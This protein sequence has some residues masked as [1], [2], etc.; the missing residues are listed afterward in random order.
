MSLSDEKE[1]LLSQLVDHE[2]PADQADQVLA[3]ILDELAD[4]LDDT[5]SGRR[6]RDMLQLRQTLGVWRQ[7]ELPRAI[8]ALPPAPSA[9]HLSHAPWRTMS[10]AVAAVL[11]GILV[12]AGFY[13]GGQFSGP[14][15]GTPI[16]Q[17]NANSAGQPEQASPESPR[18]VIVVTPE[19]RREIARAFALHE[20]VA[21]PLSWYVADD[22]TIHVAP[23]GKGER[24]QQTIAVVLRMT[25]A[26]LSNSKEAKTYVIVCRSND[27]AS[28]ELPQ[29]AMAKTSRLRLLSTVSHG[30]VNLQYVLAVEGSDRAAGDAAL[31]GQRRLGLGQTGLGQ[32]A[33]N[34]CLVNVDA[35]A[36]V[37]RGE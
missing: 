17:N 31:A 6:L 22:S 7:Q 20:S 23:L 11:G 9:A 12:A 1:L 3:G 34:E 5:E 16:A 18:S 28:I 15:P 26:L 21:G 27:A 8:I 19:E 36:W 37:L 29:S 30:E 35:S 14:R 10:L 24:P 13:L 33:M 4:V 25:P 2:L 32:L